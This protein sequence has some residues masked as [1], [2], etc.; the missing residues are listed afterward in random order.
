[1]NSDDRPLEAPPIIQGEPS[2]RA[3]WGIHLV[4]LA[5][6]PTVLGVLPI[7]LAQ[8]KTGTLLPKETAGLLVVMG[9]ELGIFAIVFM[10]AWAA[11]RASWDQLRLRWRD[12]V[13]PV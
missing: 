10:L 12:G 13:K 7:I 8:P 9:V 3:R 11:S 1:M 6:Y 2:S 4:L 5:M